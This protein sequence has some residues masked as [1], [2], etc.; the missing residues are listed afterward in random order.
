MTIKP[1]SETQVRIEIN[2]QLVSPESKVGD[3]AIKVV[4]AVAIPEKKEMPQEERARYSLSK[5]EV[6]GLV[7][8][9][10]IGVLGPIVTNPLDKLHAQIVVSKNKI[11]LVATFKK[12]P[13]KGLGIS[14]INSL[15]KSFLTFGAI[16]FLRH[17]TDKLTTNAQQSKLMAAAAAGT[18]EAFVMSPLDLLRIR[19]HTTDQHGNSLEAYRAIPKGKRTRTLFYGAPAVA[20]RNSVWLPS[21]FAISDFISSQDS[22]KKSTVKDSIIGATAGVAAARL[23]YPFDVIARHQKACKMTEGSMVNVTKHIFKEEGLKGFSKGFWSVAA[24]R[25]IIFGALARVVM[26]AVDRAL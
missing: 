4:V 2:T 25:M 21:F 7:S 10:A 12:S 15:S 24:P 16:P 1:A 23:S 22:S 26:E 18:L 14:I 3:V 13:F 20:L 9:A 6:K 17:G 8:S 19:L 5:D 11:D